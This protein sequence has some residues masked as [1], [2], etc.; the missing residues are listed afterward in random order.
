MNTRT[1]LKAEVVTVFKS[2]LAD[3]DLG[4]LTID[5]GLN[6]RGEVGANVRQHTTRTGSF[7]TTANFVLPAEALDGCTCADLDLGVCAYHKAMYCAVHEAAH[8]SEGSTNIPTEKEW[9]VY[10]THVGNE[11]G[12]D[13]LAGVTRVV[14]P[15]SWLDGVPKVV[16]LICN[17]FEDARVDRG[18][19]RTANAHLPRGMMD[20]ADLYV[21]GS[22]EDME[23]HDQYLAGLLLRSNKFKTPLLHPAINQAL[24]ELEEEGWFTAV[25][26]PD[27]TVQVSALA[28]VSAFKKGKEIGLFPDEPEP[29]K[30]EEKPESDSTDPGEGAEGDDPGDDPGDG[31]KKV[32]PKEK[33]KKKPAKKKPKKKRIAKREVTKTG[34]RKLVKKSA[35]EPRASRYID[36]PVTESGPREDPGIGLEADKTTIENLSLDHIWWAADNH[37][38]PPTKRSIEDW[39]RRQE[40]RMKDAS[41]SRSSFHPIVVRGTTGLGY[42]EFPGGNFDFAWDSEHVVTKVKFDRG[43]INSVIPELREALAVNLRSRNVGGL[44]WGRVRGAALARVPSGY[45]RVFRKQ[46]KP[47][48][49]SYFAVI[50]VDLSAST[51]SW[52][53]VDTTLHQHIKSM[54][55]HQAELLDRLNVPF[56]VYG[57]SGQKVS[58]NG[59]FAIKTPTD[60]WDPQKLQSCNALSN[61]L[62]GFAMAFAMRVAQNQRATDRIIF[63]YTDGGFPAEDGGRQKAILTLESRRVAASKRTKRPIHYVVVQ[64]DTQA[65][66]DF[67]LDFVQCDTADGLAKNLTKVTKA[68]AKELT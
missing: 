60:T 16:G 27:N 18:I 11:L 45:D 47:A 7:I 63:H 6:D 46:L 42:D 65:G 21:N 34:E 36:D 2:C 61:N 29:E 8:I 31:E 38:V 30:P 66:N 39:A 35:D 23:V 68:I 17:A 57:F 32:D 48:R 54:A 12:A 44:K 59:L 49:R 40:T 33:P 9:G 10:K 3:K 1:N 53:G 20:R 67:P 50:L 26:D 56:A 28:A 22:T 51:C 64:V 62:D 58:G 37:D 52:A 15:Q 43:A 41:K 24:D 55:L 4:A 5:V 14:K 25:R 13:Y 19:N